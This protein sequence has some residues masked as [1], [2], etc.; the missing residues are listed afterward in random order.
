MRFS[1][2]ASIR[3]TFC[4][5]SYFFIIA[6]AHCIQLSLNGIANYQVLNQ[7]YYIA[8]LYVPESL[9]L[10]AHQ[11]AFSSTQNKQM[12]LLVNAQRWSPRFWQTQWQNDLDINNPN[13]S[14]ELLKQISTFTK[15]LK[16]D[17]VTGDL[18]VFDYQASIGTHVF[19]NDQLM[20]STDSMALFNALLATWIGKLPPS[21]DFKKRIL[22]L[23]N[24][25]ITHTNIQKLYTN[26]ISEQRKTDILKWHYSNNQ[27]REIARKKENNAQEILALK[28][29]LQARKA[30][31][32]AYQK[33]K[34]R[35]AKAIALQKKQLIEKQRMLEMKKQTKLAAQATLTKIRNKEQALKEKKYYKDL[36]HWKLY[37]AI[38][39]NIQYPIWAREF[40]QEGTVK[41]LFTIDHQ[42]KVIDTQFNGEEV[43]NFLITEV[44]ESIVEVSGKI[45]PPKK[46]SGKQWQFTLNHNFSFSSKKQNPVKPPVKPHHL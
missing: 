32:L 39:K 5:L 33:E 1:F 40:N 31:R 21:R 30:A 24:D 14:K 36:Y 43:S 22:T 4:L 6:S 26:T 38:R 10:N 28:A 23:S 41:A 13:A 20:Q 2:I 37:T 35:Q 7:D 34:V 3:L 8:A 19:I 12:K 18:V 42:G 45:L 17:L 44:K 46:L 16:A 9:K 11:E 27:L 29:R 25:Q 15:L